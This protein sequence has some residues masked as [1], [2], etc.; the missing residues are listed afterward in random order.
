MSGVPPP[1]VRV[2][3]PATRTPRRAFPPATAPTDADTVYARSLVRAQLR[4]AILAVVGFGAALVA[5]TAALAL[6]PALREAV[7][8]GIPLGWLV[9]GVGIYPLILGTGLAAVGAARRLED[10]YRSLTDES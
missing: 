2:T 9:L 6:V 1:R 8:G 10:R 3:A 7:V 5:V 4:V